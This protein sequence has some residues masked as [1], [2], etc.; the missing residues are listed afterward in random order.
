MSREEMR[1][2]TSSSSLKLLSRR[3]ASPIANGGKQLFS[4]ID[5]DVSAKQTSMPVLRDWDP[6]K[7][8]V[9]YCGGCAFLL[10]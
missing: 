6:S 4:G 10:A 7:L 5:L 9:L 3:P 8:Y 1:W 2:T